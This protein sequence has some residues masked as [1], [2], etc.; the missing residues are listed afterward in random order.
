MVDRT[1]A[2]LGKSLPEIDTRLLSNLKLQAEADWY[3]FF[4]GRERGRRGIEIVNMH[5]TSNWRL[6]NIFTGLKR[7]DLHMNGLL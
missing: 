4:G 6:S 3:Y 1:A 5:S 2:V 7:I